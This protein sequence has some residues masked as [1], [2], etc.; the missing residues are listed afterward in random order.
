MSKIGKSIERERLVVTSER[1][2]AC[3][4]I[5]IISSFMVMKIFYN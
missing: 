4:V 2:W 3:L 5:G 1:R